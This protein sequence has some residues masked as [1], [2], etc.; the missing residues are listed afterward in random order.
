MIYCTNGHRID[1]TNESYGGIICGICGATF[2][3]ESDL[4]WSAD[5]DDFAVD[6]LS[7]QEIDEVEVL[8]LDVDL[9][10]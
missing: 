2:K 7:D 9:P 1:D 3:T 8:P 5:E 4:D 10:H 6:E